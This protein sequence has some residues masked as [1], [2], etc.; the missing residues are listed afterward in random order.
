LPFDLCLCTQA[1]ASPED[2]SGALSALT[3]VCA[4][5]AL[6]VL[7]FSLR[8]EG[9]EHIG[10]AVSAPGR[11]G[12]VANAQSYLDALVLAAVLGPLPLRARGAPARGA[13]GA[14]LLGGGTTHFPPLSF[15][16]CVHTSGGC[17][18]PFRPEAFPAEGAADVLPIALAYSAANSFNA[19]WAAHISTAA[20]VAH[21]F[22]L[23]AA[24]MKVARVQV[25]PRAAPAPGQDGAS[26]LRT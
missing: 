12:V 1:C 9:T 23:T 13:P 15:P 25:L 8:V 24:W 18:L 19:A 20:T 6:A 22:R 4:R 17:M 7:G 10:A 3:C 16:E 2:G 5:L 14:R 21:A 26:A 11:F